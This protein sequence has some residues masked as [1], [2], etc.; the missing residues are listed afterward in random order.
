MPG[1]RIEQGDCR[2]LFC[3][4]VGFAI[5]LAEAARLVGSRSGAPAIEHREHPG[6]V[7]PFE[8]RPAPLRIR[9]PLG[10][11]TV[12]PF[13]LGPEV[14][15]TLYDFGAA[16]VSYAIPLAPGP[17][18]LLELSMAL[19]GH[20]GLVTDARRRIG[21]RIEALGPAIER[22]KLAERF[23]DFFLFEIRAIEG[24]PDATVL[25]HEHAELLARV[26]RAETTELSE[27]EIADA[28]EARLSFGKRDVTLVDWDAGIIVDREPDELRAVLEFANVQLLELRYLDDEL[29]RT[30]E[31]SYQLLSR[32]HNWRWMWPGFQG[33]EWRRLSTLQVESAVL[34]ERVTNAL[35]FLGEEYLARLY[36]MAAERLHLGEWAAAITR[37]LQTLDGIHKT[38]SE[39]A[40]ARRMEVLEWV[41]ILLIALEIVLAA[42]G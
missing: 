2:P 13:R 7:G 20:A 40:S 6:G 15:L 27:A 37:K 5:D 41:I 28:I 9:E 42:V 21:A 24:T 30:L 36:R 4:E 22:P 16:S 23:E 17:A 25:C 26:L 8:F 18:E 34:L 12:P 11:A 39:R 29:D 3:F 35:K 14:E 19:R 31:R 1:F 38:M 33:D 32:R 10:N